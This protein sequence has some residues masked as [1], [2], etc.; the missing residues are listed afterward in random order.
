MTKETDPYRRIDQ[1]EQDA[2]QLLAEY[3]GTDN[4]HERRIALIQLRAV[5]VQRQRTLDQIEALE[6]LPDLWDSLYGGVDGYLALFSGLRPQKRLERPQEGYF[7]YPDRVDEAQA[8]VRTAA[9]AGREVYHCAHLLTE[10]R[11]R[12]AYAA[13]LAALWVDLDHAHLDQQ[14]VPMPSIVVESS[15]G[16][17]QCYWQLRK[18]VDPATGEQVNRQLAQALGADVSGWLRHEVAFVA[19]RR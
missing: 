19:V 6:G 1:F 16:R 3:N 5:D 18:P 7:P 17:L 10:P 8:W 9:A 12:K 2:L 11:R 13:P 4:E 15:P 14:V